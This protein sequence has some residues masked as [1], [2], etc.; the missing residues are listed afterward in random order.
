MGIFRL[1]DPHTEPE[2]RIEGAA[3]MDCIA[4]RYS[5]LRQKRR[6]FRVRRSVWIPVPRS[7]DFRPEVAPRKQLLHLFQTLLSRL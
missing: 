2:V 6:R 4:L 3:A 5:T 1:S 7:A